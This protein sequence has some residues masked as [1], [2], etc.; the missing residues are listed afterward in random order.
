M[1]KIWKYLDI[2]N[3]QEISDEVYNYVVNCTNILQPIHS[4]FYTDI[5]IPHIL[6]YSPSLSE[7]LNQ[8]FLVPDFILVW[9]VPPW[10]VPYVHVDFIDPCVKL[11]W[12][13]QNCAKSQIKFYDVPK[14]FL[15]LNVDPREPTNNYYEITE[16][17][18]WPVL[19]E[20]NLIR[21]IAFDAS[22]AHAVY[23]APDVTE[24]RISFTLEFNKD[25]FVSKSFEAWS[26]T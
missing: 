6:K 13:A 10:A 4:R 25:L 15:K 16:E 24:Y 23:T 3:H 14:E 5:N 2:P 7:F 22:V 11:I 8:R 26:K 19:E 1:N 21:P 12:P 18:D 17:R 9:A 20:A